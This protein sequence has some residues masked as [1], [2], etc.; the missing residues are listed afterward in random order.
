[1][2]LLS[3]SIRFD[4]YC[5]S[6]DILL[7]H[8]VIFHAYVCI[9]MLKSFVMHSIGISYGR[10]ARFHCQPLEQTYMVWNCLGAR[11]IA[12]PTFVYLICAKVQIVDNL[13]RISFLKMILTF[14]KSH[15][16]NGIL[17][18]KSMC[19][20]FTSIQHLCAHI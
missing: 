20:N 4:W 11:H 1:M 7:K 3:I 8:L 5:F 16:S 10:L 18:L 9:Y 13:S 15:L 14:M 6:I 17:I 19:T 2:S 12:C